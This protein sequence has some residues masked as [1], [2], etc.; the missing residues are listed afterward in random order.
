MAKEM[1]WDASQK[2]LIMSSFFSGYLMTQIPGGMLAQRVGAKIVLAVAVTGSAICFGLIPFANSLDQVSGGL[3]L[4]SACLFFQGI[5]Q[6]PII[7]SV[8]LLFS[9]WVPIEEQP[10]AQ[11][12]Q[13]VMITACVA[14]TNLATPYINDWFGWRSSFY[15]YAGISIIAVI[16]WQLLGA[17]GPATCSGISKEERELL[18]RTVA[19]KEQVDSPAS[20]DVSAPLFPWFLFKSTAVW[21]AII[22]NFIS[23][24]GLYMFKNWGPTIYQE[25][26]GLGPK[27]AGAF[28]A[29][30]D[31]FATIANLLIPG[32]RT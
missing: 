21:A 18:A 9:K 1:G 27:K 11:G 2:S 22:A 14:G 12:L 3:T 7:P 4:Q 29:S 30:Q 13:G 8:T 15:A 28:L 31:T 6:G 19:L 24:Y 23:N 10:Q 26:H 5:F 20:K 25:L 32:D 16:L 17:A